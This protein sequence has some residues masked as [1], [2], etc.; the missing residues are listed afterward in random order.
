[1]LVLVTHG[2]GSFAVKCCLLKNLLQI[3]GEQA[4][5]SLKE[6][7]GQPMFTFLFFFLCPLL[8]NKGTLIFLAPHESQTNPGL[9]DPAIIVGEHPRCRATQN[10]PRL[11]PG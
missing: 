5:Q 2:A 4:F 10:L 1:M 7:C 6:N 3:K 9:W 8:E 11:L